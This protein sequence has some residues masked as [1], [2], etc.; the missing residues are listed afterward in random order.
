MSRTIRCKSIR[1]P[2]WIRF[3][4][5]EN[6]FGYNKDMPNPEM[7]RFGAKFYS[8]SWYKR[9]ERVIGRDTE[10][11]LRMTNKEEMIRW[12]KDEDYE[13]MFFRQKPKDWSC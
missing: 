5:D 4:R 10:E 1:L 6:S 11:K 13:P 12:L 8:D 2:K 7:K 3:E 9:G